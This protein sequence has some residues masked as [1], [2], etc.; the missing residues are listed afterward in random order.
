[1][2]RAFL[3]ATLMAAG[4]SGCRGA[5]V[6]TQNLDVVLSSTDNF[7]Y[8]GATTNRWKDLM[9]TG[10]NSVRSVVSAADRPQTEQS[11]PNPTEFAYE[12][13][14]DLAASTQGPVP[15][16]HNEQVRVITRFAVYAPSQLCR[17]LALRQLVAHAERLELSDAFEPSAAPASPAQLIEAVDGLTDALRAVSRRR[18]D[19]TARADFAAAIALAEELEV[20]VQGGARLLR[21]LGPFLRGWSISGDLK[22]Q[23]AE[24]SERVQRRMVAEALWS[25]GRDRSTFV[26]ATGLRVGID[27]Y[28]DPYRIEA[29][30]ALVPNPAMPP[31]MKEEFSGFQLPPPPP[32]GADI[33]I[34]V[35]E[36]YEAEGLPLAAR[37][38]TKRGLEL[39]AALA[40][41]FLQVA[42]LDGVFDPRAQHAAMG[43]LSAMSA[44]ELV[45]LRSEDWITWGEGALDRLAEQIQAVEND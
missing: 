17:E 29:L 9:V 35:A 34:A 25:G 20:D 12:N 40:T 1:M 19:E 32:G 10:L 31:W 11:I 43:A 22:A 36:A 45:S 42:I 4:L 8:R 26:R 27:V 2:R 16:R 18:T 39:R 14:V 13:L 44:G 23:V 38:E 5:S 37:R 7:R 6:A 21:A 33:Y 15:W 41:A 28:G 30:L 24:L 3:I